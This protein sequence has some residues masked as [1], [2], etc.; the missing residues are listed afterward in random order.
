MRSTLDPETGLLGR[1]A[2]RE[3]L[4]LLIA[5]A[6]SGMSGAL[7]VRGDPGAGK[8]ALLDG[9]PARATGF[10]VVRVSGVESEM[11]LA[12][13]GLHQLCASFLDR[14]D[15]LP[16]PQRDAIG[17][18]LGLRDGAAP[19]RFLVGLAVLS[20]LSD[21]ADAQPLACLVDDAQWVD[22]ASIQVLGFVARRLGAE[23]V[24]LI[25]GAR[26][27][28]EVPDLAGLPQLTIRPLTVDDARALLTAVLPGRLDAAVR[29]RIIA[30]AH[31][32]PLALLELPRGWTPAG[33]A[34]G[35]GLPDGISVSGLIEE[36]Y[37]GRLLPLPDDTRRLLLV[38]A[39]E[40]AADPS[41]IWAAAGRLGIAAG[42]DAPA[43]TAGLLESG[44]SLRFRHP[45]VRTVVYREAS[46]DDRRRA[47]HALAEATDGEN[48][49]DRRAWHLA[50]AAAGPDEDVAEELE[51]SAA[52]AQARGGITAAA[53]FLDRAVALTPDPARRA[54]R[55]LAAAK[56]SQLA[57]GHDAAEASLA[58]A[59]A[60]PLDAHGRAMAELCRGAIAFASNHG[61]DAPRLLLDAARQLDPFDGAAARNTY[62]EALAAAMFVGRL[63]GDV[64]IPEVG[65]A[66][67]ESKRSSAQPA[68]LLLDGFASV[69]TDGYVAGAPR[70]RRA[71]DAFL[72]Q[73]I[74]DPNAIRWLWLAGHAAQDLW[75]PDAW[76]TLSV[77]H[78]DLVRR[79]G[80]LGVMP[81]ALNLRVG[82]HLFAG[83]LDDAD[84]LVHEMA[85][86]V[87]AIGIP[88]P[89]FSALALAA[90]RGREADASALASQ[91]L[92]AA[93]SRGD[94]F[95]TTLAHHAR[96]VL[97]NGLGRYE[98]AF[99]AAESGAAYPV[100]MAYSAGSLVQLI[101]A[102][103]R[104]GH[105][106]R[107]AEAVE[108]LSARTRASGTD[109]AMGVEARGRA[110][111]SEGGAAEEA[112][113]ASIDHL[114]R[115]RLAAELARSQLVFGEW[116]RREGRRV[117][118][119]AQLRAAY[120]LFRAAGAE[121][122]AERARI[123]LLATGE[124]VR[125][126]TAGTLDE[127]TPQEMQ[128]ARLAR[129]GL[130]NPE[131]GA[132]LF[133]SPRTVEWHLRKVF[134]K[135][136]VSSRKELR[137]ALP[138]DDRIAVST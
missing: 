4:D 66:A 93:T 18:A 57:G 7:V 134:S 25:F 128:I 87:K 89:P 73:D 67:M 46:T 11:E 70:L 108:E 109:W 79:A 31:G 111:V 48:D 16:A 6:R 19:D 129:G 13:A 24:V 42:A 94:G 131:I 106:E 38:A 120:D 41:V 54:G 29:E 110:L 136:G 132:Q 103:V 61:R 58:I 107:A 123:E 52:R 26:S 101:E 72:T 50:A 63:A 119:R 126:R 37:R 84:L 92:S 35:F 65:A 5:Q 55:A 36:S 30:E 83:E 56:A 127:L 43:V 96:A 137:G 15:T 113:R 44:P 40:S 51:R 104:S 3:Q 97:F 130:S 88:I 20:L 21:V 69:I 23:A 59:D 138:Q 122:F 53:A 105:P 8:T 74:P 112:Y 80:A 27:S 49:A 77:R 60:G 116:L 28:V 114:G 32:N 2:E 47:H 76:E 121:A 85:T 118:A 124:T 71:V 91:V 9:V 68:D 34:G 1:A 45:L 115:T 78:L 102:A 64:G 95:G 75:D 133:L 81:I 39:A 117:D 90:W 10:R 99:A 17:T 14:V 22:Q 12:F 62:L 86:V 82:R 98:D 33:L 100:E 125:K 135:L